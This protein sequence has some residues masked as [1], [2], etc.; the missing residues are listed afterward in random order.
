MQSRLGS[1]LEISLNIFIG[2]CIAVIAQIIIFPYFGL[3]VSLSDNMLIA[4]LF[5]IVSFA[6]GYI[7][8]R[9]FNWYNQ[10]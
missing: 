8:R 3:Y 7:I 4:A 10:T 6:R 1:L 9:V 2:Y 5:T